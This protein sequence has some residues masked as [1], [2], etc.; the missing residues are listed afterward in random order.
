MSKTAENVIR[1][2]IV[3]IAFD[4]D[5]RGLAGITSEVDQL[6]SSVSGVSGSGLET[7]SSQANGAG[8]ALGDAA[9]QAQGLGREI[10]GTNDRLGE[11]NR[12]SQQT[13]S[14]L[15][16]IGKLAMTQL[17]SGLDKVGS[18]LSN[19][20]KKAAGAAYNG[21]KKL[22]GISFKTLSVG[23]G[24]ATVAVG[25]LVTQAV[26]AYANTEQLVG[27]VETLLG[28]KGAKNVEEYA[29]LVGK[30]VSEVEKEYNNLMTSQKTVITNANNAYKTAGLSANE[31]METVTGF[32]A[33]LLQSVGG[34]T[35]KAAEL[36]DVAISD[37]ADNANK[38]G[39][40]M[41]SIQW[42]YQG[43]AKQNYTMLD[44]LKLGYGGT[45]SEM[46]R[47]VADA[48]KLDK[49]IDANSLSYANIVKAIHAVQV[50]TGIYG[51]TQ[52]EAEH[53]IQGSLNSM[54]S[55]W[56]NLLPALIQGGDS[57]DQC[58]KNLVSS[59]KTF[60]G[61][62]MP[63]IKSALSGVGSLITELTPIIVQE[64]PSIAQTILPPLISAAISVMQGLI[65]AMP[66]ILNTLAAQLPVLISTLLP[67]AASGIVQIIRGIGQVIIQNAPA[68]VSA[69][70]QAILM[71]VQTIY[72]GFTGNSM[73]TTMFANLKTTIETVFMS[74][75][76]IIMGVIQFGQIMWNNLAPV[77]AFIGN[78]ALTLFNGIANNINIILPIL[79]TLVVAFVVLKT[80]MTIVNAVSAIH[81]AVTAVMAAK[82]ALATGAT[83]A[84]TAA[85]NGNNATI[86]AAIMLKGK[87]AAAW[88]ASKAA[89]IAST[90]ATKAA[91]LGQALLN[92]TLLACP[93]TWII[94]GIMALI[95]VFI[96]LYNKCEWVRNAV[97]AIGE[98]I[99]WV[100]EKIGGF[101]SWCKEKLGFE[102]KE[103]GK[104]SGTKLKEGF[105]EGSS[106]LDTSA[107]NLGTGVDSGLANGINMSSYLPTTA[108]TST[109]NQTEL[110]LSGVTD[111]SMYGIQ[112]NT[113]LASGL[114]ATSYMPVGAASNTEML[115][116]NELMKL[117]NSTSQYGAQ[118]NTNL[119]SGLNSTA[120]LPASAAANTEMLTDNELQKVMNTS[121]YGTQ[122]T[123]NLASG[124]SA[125]SY[126]PTTAAA[127]LATDT[128]TALSGV[129][130]DTAQIGSQAA[131]NFSSGFTNGSSSVTSAMGTVQNTISDTM[132]GVSENVSNGSNQAAEAMNAN[133]Q[134]LV[135]VVTTN[136]GK[137][138]NAVKNSM[139]A[140]KMTVSS[141][142]LSSSGA[143]M[144]DGL[145]SGMNS[146]R[147]ALISTAQSMANAV[148]STINSALDIHSPSRVLFETGANTAQ[149]N[150]DGIKSKLPETKLVAQEMGEMS[151]PYSQ[152]YTP[153]NS[154]TSTT[155][156]T[157]TIE[158]NT[159]NPEFNATFYTN[160]TDRDAKSKFKRWFDE[161][162]SEFFASADRRYPR[163]TEV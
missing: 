7:L 129:S 74:I 154:P 60:A 91:A 132:N 45:K 118:A 69:A 89:M 103:T 152:T 123:T 3:Q 17:N 47:L 52:K 61:N 66:S 137:A 71:V 122:A 59:V 93:I 119:A 67:A 56:G 79:N 124:I 157:M 63:A 44:N 14:S 72:E 83:V 106:G 158:R 139:A 43:F 113:N 58:V 73:S 50:E 37:M 131:T 81:G 75:Q 142:N 62:I 6:R 134:K 149:G 148:K 115:T 78:I 21:L 153:Q 11:T 127:G 101:F 150:I 82:E 114:N 99:G 31:Y 102:S 23:I 36:A 12:Q 140:I 68:L 144:I 38:M 46:Q 76:K 133:M 160:G 2:D 8:D 97:N 1:Q 40:D 4:V 85:Q 145:I 130:N 141:C 135:K 24:A 136:L 19:I 116:D 42:A 87:E 108:A 30:S 9:R 143:S 41:S 22:A 98:A 84:A 128:K 49:S 151:I 138:V 25:G 27:G 88:V 111:T 117:S 55:A 48:A 146:R 16:G 39:T 121:Q 105:N 147:G 33:S 29:K 90:V 54:R 35:I 92:G 32:S 126:A 15:K 10:G 95:A 53:T 125:G 80:I 65:N 96:L 86:L 161:A 155:S 100:V 156:R 26:T 28:A 51:T 13:Q 77:F 70:K 18:H 5:N 20:A 94:I 112:A 107:F 162:M 34:D 109:A 57:F 104:E 159:Y 163:E 110:A 120:Y 64:I